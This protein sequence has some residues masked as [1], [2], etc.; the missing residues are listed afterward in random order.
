[1]ESPWWCNPNFVPRQTE[2]TD[3]TYMYTYTIFYFLQYSLYIL[4]CI[5]LPQKQKQILYLLINDWLLLTY[6]NLWT[7]KRNKLKERKQKSTNVSIYL[8][9]AIIMQITYLKKIILGQN[10]ETQTFSIDSFSLCNRINFKQGSNIMQ[11]NYA[12]C[13][14]KHK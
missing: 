4:H 10:L 6:V 3:H 2:T 12:A 7:I 8:L 14:I 13:K 1:M 9:H 5:C 11:S